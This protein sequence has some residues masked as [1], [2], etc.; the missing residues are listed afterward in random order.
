MRDMAGQIAAFS[1]S[2]VG[3][4]CLFFALAMGLLTLILSGAF[5][6][7][8]AKWGGIFLG[9]LLVLDLG[10]ADLPWL[11]FWNY[12]QKY[13]SNPIDRFASRQTL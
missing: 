5:A 9:T 7:R 3:W 8:R 4:F 11:V 2:Q 1:V 12:P 6:G 10:R 13:A